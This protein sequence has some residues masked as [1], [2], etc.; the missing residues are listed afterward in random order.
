M[1]ALD[2]SQEDARASPSPSS[3]SPMA[4]DN[5][6]AD[7]SAPEVAKMFALSANERRGLLLVLGVALLQEVHWS[8]F[9][10]VLVGAAAASALFSQ[11][12]CLTSK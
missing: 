11:R 5:S 2:A 6:A 10:G 7:G 3:S 8:A 4:G 1:S 9:R 12:K